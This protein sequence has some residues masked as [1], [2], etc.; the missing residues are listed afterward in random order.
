[1][2]S[3]SL[4][5]IGFAVALLQATVV[6]GTGAEPGRSAQTVLA[7]DTPNPPG[8]PRSSL[9]REET[10]ALDT[11]NLADLQAAADRGE[12][13]AQWKL[14]GLHAYGVGL[15]RSDA[16]ALKWCRR[17]ADQG[18]SNAQVSLGVMYDKGKG[19]ERDQTEALR[20]YQKAEDQGNADGQYNL[21]LMYLEG[22]GTSQDYSRAMLW[23]GTAAQQGDA[24]AQDALGDMFLFGKGV[25]EDDTEAIRWYRKAADQGLASAQASLGFVYEFSESL[26]DNLGEGVRWYRLAAD[27]GNAEAQYRLGVSYR[28]GRGIPKDDI[29]AYRWFSRAAANS[30]TAYHQDAT[31]ELFAVASELPARTVLDPPLPPEPFKLKLERWWNWLSMTFG[32]V[33]GEWIL[34]AMLIGVGMILRERMQSVR[35]RRK[36]AQARSTAHRE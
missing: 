34:A 20:W 12:A 17:A 24:D 18:Y 29:Q 9:K 10:T 33:L 21:G 22:A 3:G 16:E 32:Y 8:P 26:P 28:D 7:Q 2:K 14:G 23:F 11:R 35:A 13:D 30:D 4:I 15:A 5:V 19:V 31:K 27:Q 25:A 36:A 1:M 6:T